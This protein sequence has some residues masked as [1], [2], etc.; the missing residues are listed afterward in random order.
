MVGITLEF[1]QC[2]RV[3]LIIQPFFLLGLMRLVKC[4]PL[5]QKMVVNKPGLPKI[6]RKQ[7]S[8]LGIRVETIAKGFAD[9]HIYR[10]IIAHLFSI[11]S[12]LRFAPRLSSA[13]LKIA[14]FSGGKFYK[15][16]TNQP[17][18]LLDISG[19]VLNIQR[20][21][22][23]DGPGIRT[24]VFLK[25]CSLRCKWCGNPESIQKKPEISYDPRKCTGKECSVCLN[26]PFPEGAFYFMDGADDKVSVNWHLAMDCDQELAS[27]CPTGA[28][29]MFGKT[30]TVG[31]VLD[32]VEKD[33]SFYRSTGGGM[34]IS[35]G[36][37]MLQPDFAAALLQ[38]AH[39]RGIN[40]AIETA[41]NAPWSFLEKVLPHVDT[42]LHD[43]KLMN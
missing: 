36:E 25:G 14:R 24:T 40:T 16:M 38:E 5:R 42:M 30:M 43:N 33:S 6:D 21:C 2:R 28:L 18:N 3:I 11:L 23:H 39:N 32:E 13:Q 19:T 34:T 37:V 15:M 35:G 7:V 29:E 22:S 12:Q 10:T 41:S 26:S 4:F 8:L 9:D 27:L 20:Y 1:F 31:E 17:V